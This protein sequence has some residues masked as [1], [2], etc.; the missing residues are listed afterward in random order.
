[1]H[2]YRIQNVFNSIVC[3]YY[4]LNSIYSAARCMICSMM[5]CM[6]HMIGNKIYSMQPAS[7]ILIV[8]YVF[9]KLT[10]YCTVVTI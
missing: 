10:Y 8:C 7:T 9:I 1:M 4:L 6:L 2:A 5:Y 3:E